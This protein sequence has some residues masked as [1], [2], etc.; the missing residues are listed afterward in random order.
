MNFIFWLCAF[1]V[2][3]TYLGYPLL[4]AWL[5]KHKSVSSSLRFTDV[6]GLPRVAV[7]IAAYNEEVHIANRIKNILSSELSVDRLAIYIGSDGS[8]DATVAIIKAFDDPRVK[9]LEFG[10]RRGK[11]Q[12]INDLVAVASEE[13]LIF[14]DANTVFAPDTITNLLRHFVDDNVGCVC[15][16][17]NLVSPLGGDNQ[18]HLYWRYERWL[19]KQEASVG[20]LLGANGG[21]YALRRELY[22]PLSPNTLIDDF[23]ISME[24]IRA[25]WKCLYDDEAK[26]YETT[27]LY[28]DDEFGRRVR[29]GIGN[30]QALVYFADLLNP[31]RGLLAL[32]FFSHKCLRWLVP[33]LLVLLLV[34]N[35]WLLDQLFF[36][37][38]LS[39]QF[40]FYAFAAL[41]YF[42]GKRSSRVPKAFRLPLFFVSMNLALGIGFVKFLTQPVVWQWARTQR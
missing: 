8:D 27:P 5:A 23:W 13:L 33:H 31:K 32:A 14:T 9:L 15:G 36:V 37:Y 18:D 39:A 26:A 34:M 24:V 21:V 42:L 2:V 30:Y 11:P 25:G 16:E 40:V 10:T 19:K 35:F 20:A 4:I 29:I 12:V 1:G 17:L 6:N 41:G 3:Y 38:L 22:K 28:I 7:L